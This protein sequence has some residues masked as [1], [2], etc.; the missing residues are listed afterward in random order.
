MYKQGA[1]GHQRV[2]ELQK[3]NIFWSKLFK[4]EA[5]SRCCK[6]FLED[7]TW[8]LFEHFQF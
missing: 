2:Y 8:Q 7:F 4:D 3:R 5:G 6:T 1:G